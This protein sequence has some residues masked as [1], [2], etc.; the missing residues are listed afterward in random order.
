MPFR[1]A[2]SIFLCQLAWVP[3]FAHAALD[4]DPCHAAP[5][6][7]SV[8]AR[9]FLSFDQFDRELRAAITRQDA[10]A[11]AFLVTFPLRVNDAGGTI[12]IDN[13]AALKMNFQQ[14]FTA[15]VRKAI[16]NQKFDD[17]G[18]NQ[19]GIGYGLG[20][21]WVNASDRGYAI[22]S[23]NRDAVPPYPST[24]TAPT[25]NYVCQTPTHRILVETL[26]KGTLRYRSWNKPRFVT[27][28]PDLVITGG[29]E[30]VEG[31]G[32][33]AVSVYTFKSGAAVYS[34]DGGL[35]CFADSEPGPPK[36]ATGQLVVTTTGKPLVDSWCF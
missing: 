12:S 9:N 23:V 29:K 24:R 6:D 33:C 34:V 17:L 10:V 15:A 4:R 25:I 28:P 31:T 14:V 5:A 22:W 3:A 36:D 11:L 26:S 18:C 21:I 35:G 13:A 8:A 7:G 1:F 32:V 20:V 2:I 16:L 19:E 27:V 30:T